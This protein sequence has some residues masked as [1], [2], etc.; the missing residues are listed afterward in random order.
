MDKVRTFMLCSLLLLAGCKH[1]NT[2]VELVKNVRVANPEPIGATSVKYFSGVIKEAAAVNLS[3]KA[4][5]QILRIHVREGQRVQQGDLIAELDAKDYRLQLEATEAQY[6]QVKAE[7]QRIEELYKR[8]SISG[9]DYEKAISAK[10]MLTAKLQADRNTLEYTRL[11]APFAGYIQSV[12]FK[13]SEVVNAGMSV[14]TLIDVRQMVVEINIPASLYVQR[15]SFASFGCLADVLP[16]KVF[17]LKLISINPK[18]DSHQLYKMQLQL[19]PKQDARLAA[20]M[21]VRVAI[22]CAARSNAACSLPIGAVFG[23]DGKSYVWVLDTVTSRVQKR[24]V[25]VQGVDG[26]GGVAVSAGVTCEDNV[27]VAGA[28]SLRENQQVRALPEV[29]EANVGGL[30]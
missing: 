5:G 20:G 23:E 21:N 28:K 12:H 18:A 6:E 11:V 27:V 15:E 26:K 7:V 3:F 25:T 29:S 4:A 14:A 8:K 16:D 10:K 24:E 13:P 1:S 30:L 17:P 19:D 22:T 9:N 2:P